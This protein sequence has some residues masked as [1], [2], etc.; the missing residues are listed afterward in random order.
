VPS[1]A[2]GMETVSRIVLGAAVF[3]GALL[4]FFGHRLL[5]VALALA[6]LLCGSAIAAYVAWW[7][8]ASAETLQM[9][10]TQ[11]DVLQAMSAPEHPTVVLVWAVVGGIAGAILAVLLQ[12]VGMFA[13]GALLGWTLVSYTM[14]GAAT[15]DYWIVLAVLGLIGGTLALLMEKPIIVLSTAV[16]GAAALMFGIYAL[17]KGYAWDEAFARLRVMGGGTYV[18]IGFAIIL[19]ALG[20]YVQFATMPKPEKSEDALYKKIDPKKRKKGKDSKS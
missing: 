15:T 5:R 16:N 6:G 11:F 2:I 12:H 19:A 4:C 17:I 10:K 14:A 20:G 7:K 3:G 18:V 9:V 1:L 13:V 8:T